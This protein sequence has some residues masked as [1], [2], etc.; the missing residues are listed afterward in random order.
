MIACDRCDNWF[1]G[2]CIGISEK[3]GE[4]IDLY[5][6]RDCAKGKRCLYFF[7][8][9]RFYPFHGCVLTHLGTVTGKGTSWKPKC[10]NPACQR[11]ARSSTHQGFISKYCDDACGLQVARARLELSEMKHRA[12]ISSLSSASS[13][14]DPLPPVVPELTAQRQQRSQINTASHREDHDR[15]VQLRQE[16]R[17]LVSQV[18]V[19]DRKLAFLKH[20]AET[21]PEICGFDSRLIWSD[22]TWARVRGVHNG[23]LDCVDPPVSFVCQLTRCPKHAGWQKVRALEFEQDRQTLFHRLQRLAKQRQQIKSRMR[24][25]LQHAQSA[26]LAHA[27]IRY[28]HHFSH[29]TTTANTH[30]D[31]QPSS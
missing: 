25:R 6:C 22:A 7:F 8:F 15:L 11:A 5:F 3:E 9:T 13:A 20:A 26:S 21:H 24:Q 1:H 31:A 28:P 10:A 4:F 17:I 14:T 27:T 18:E 30:P 16:K 12:S 19:M 2:E 23:E 29:S